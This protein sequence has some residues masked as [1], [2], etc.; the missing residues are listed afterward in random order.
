LSSSR[1]PRS[2]KASWPAAV[3]ACTCETQTGLIESSP[4]RSVAQYYDLP[5]LSQR[6]PLVSHFANFPQLTP[7]Y[8]VTE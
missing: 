6:L 5:V 1:S 7:H 2:V 8:F 3:V 4:T